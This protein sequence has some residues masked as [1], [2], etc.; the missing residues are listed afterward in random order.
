MA[1]WAMFASQLLMSVDLRTVRTSSRHLLQNRRVIAIN[2]DALGKPG[3]RVL[4]VKH[5]Y[6]SAGEAL[7]LFC[8]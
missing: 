1:M 3:K 8:R 4:Q 5:C 6:C 7:L 2:Q